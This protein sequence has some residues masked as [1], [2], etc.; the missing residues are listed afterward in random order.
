M[1]WIFEDNICGDS[2]WRPAGQTF[3]DVLKACRTANGT[4]EF[5]T[6]DCIP[7]AVGTQTGPKQI[8]GVLDNSFIKPEQMEAF[9]GDL[10]TLAGDAF[11][12]VSNMY[13]AK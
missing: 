1:F 4:K 7:F 9:S 8:L 5:L 11:R 12:R 6:Q 2:V 3:D 10:T 13:T